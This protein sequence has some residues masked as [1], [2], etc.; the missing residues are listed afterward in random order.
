[1]HRRG[2]VAG[3]CCVLS[4]HVFGQVTRPNW[5]GEQPRPE[6]RNLERVHV[7]DPW[8]EVY[9]VAPSVFAIY[10]PPQAK[11][12]ISYLTLGSKQALLFDTGM[13]I[14]DI[15]K[16]VAELTKLPVIVLNSHTHDD[17]VGGNW[18][19]DNVY[20]VDSQFT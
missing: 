10:E 4:T 12:T 3:L 8:I 19:F 5:C 2:L 14:S 7:S 16:V 1:M 9:K 15:K 11:E 18:E 17:H 13:G 20:G 6:Y